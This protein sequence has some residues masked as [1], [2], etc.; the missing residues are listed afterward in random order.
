MATGRSPFL[1]TPGAK[2][3]GIELYSLS[4]TYNMTGWR[5]AA[6]LGNADII[7]GL[8][9]VKTNLDSGAFQAI[10]YAGMTAL[11]SG[12]SCVAENNRIYEERHHVLVG[13][14]QK[15]GWGR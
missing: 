4:K 11:D 15:L 2:D 8:G 9:Q 13:G 10:Q 5:I 6:A 12:Q 14:L 1:E 7:R 3:V